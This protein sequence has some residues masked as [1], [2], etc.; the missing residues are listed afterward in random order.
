MPEEAIA[1]L[2][3]LNGRTADELIH[4]AVA[5]G[6]FRDLIRVGFIWKGT[7]DG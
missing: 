1:A 6:L 4:R 3:H 7:T 2:C 5:A